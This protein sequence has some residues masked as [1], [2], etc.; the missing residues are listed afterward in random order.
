MRLDKY[1]SS[2]TQ[3]SRSQVKE[4]IRKKLV[5][6]GDQIITSP[7]FQVDPEKDVVRLQ[8]NVIGYSQYQ[9]FLLNKP[10][11]VISATKDRLSE[12]VLSLLPKDHKKDLFP[13]GR[14]D[15]DTEGL[16]LITNDGALAH[17][18]LSPKKHVSKTYLVKLKKPLTEEDIAKLEQGVDIGDDDLTLPAYVTRI[19]DPN[20]EGDWIHLTISEG[21]FHQV[22]RMLEAVQNEVL[23]LKRIRFGGLSLDTSLKAGECRKLTEEEL[24]LLKR[25]RDIAEEKRKLLEGKKAVIFDLDGSLIDSMWIW[26]KIDEEYLGHFDIHLKSREELRMK[27]EGM[28]FYETAIFFQEYFQLPDT[29]EKMTSDWNQMAWDKYEREVPLKSGIPDF[30]AII[31]CA[32]G[33]RA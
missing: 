30:L 22:K 10:A 14:L 27:I 25:S 28:S 7:E 19:Y 33:A 5:S 18:L 1:L 21:R 24:Q 8:G 20:L 13:V 3:E 17:S 32:F 29:I 4:L 15:K 2:Q 26:G 12:T 23:F 16:L 31:L 11:G 9:Y 6:V